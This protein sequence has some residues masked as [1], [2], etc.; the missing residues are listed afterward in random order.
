CRGTRGYPG[1]AQTA[2]P[3]DR[4][5]LV[6]GR[7][8]SAASHRS[9][10]TRRCATCCRCGCWR[11]CAPA[12]PSTGTSAGAPLPT[13]RLRRCCTRSCMTTR[14][15]RTTCWPR[16]R[17]ARSRRPAP[18]SAAARRPGCTWRWPCATTAWASCAASCAPCATSRP[19]SARAC[20]TGAAAAAWRAVARRCTWPAS[21][22]APSAS[23]CCSATAPRP[24]CVTAVASRRSSCCCASWATTPGPPPPGPPLP[25]GPQRPCTGE[26]RQRRLLLL[27]LLALYTPA[28][29]AG[30]ARRELL[31]DRPRWQR[32]LGEDKFQWL[33]GL[34][35]PSLFAR[36][37]QVLVT[38]IS[39]G[40]FPEALDELPLPPFLQPLDL[41]GKG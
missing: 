34:A 8:S 20:S 3:R 10:S 39:P 24:A 28:S 16:S 41:T 17:G 1:A 4:A 38:A 2:D 23:S 15:T 7:R 36:A 40:R 18:A 37:M 26:P 31:G 25:P 5:Q 33:A 29:V 13:R 12:R 9:P 21:W 30:P 6:R 35:P 32:L 19:R 11:T 14:R 22:R 27:D